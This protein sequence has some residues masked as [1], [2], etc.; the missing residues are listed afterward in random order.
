MISRLAPRHNS[1]V[2]A[3]NARGLETHRRQPGG[4]NLFHLR[5]GAA[6][7]LHTIQLAADT[8]GVVM[9]RAAS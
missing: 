4:S 7:R 2:A 9:E 6:G 5:R 3:R 1:W 8:T